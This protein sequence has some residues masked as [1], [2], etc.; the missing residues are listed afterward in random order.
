MPVTWRLCHVFGSFQPNWKGSSAVP[1]TGCRPQPTLHP[2][3]SSFGPACSLNYIRPG[4]TS[5]VPC[6]TKST[7]YLLCKV[8]DRSTFTSSQSP[9]RA[10]RLLCHVSVG[11]SVRHELVSL[12]W[13]HASICTYPVTPHITNNSTF[14][15]SIYKQLQNTHP[16]VNWAS[17]RETETNMERPGRC[18]T[19]TVLC[20]SGAAIV[21]LS[22]CLDVSICKQIRKS[23]LYIKTINIFRLP[24][25]KWYNLIGTEWIPAEFE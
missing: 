2:L 10:N 25:S 8:D 12:G 13:I 1:P 7:D 21:T 4:T 18:G 20:A 14:V 16:R 23:M 3:R 19:W 6:D 9:P 11:R 22:H 24:Q 5:L 17:T 15:L